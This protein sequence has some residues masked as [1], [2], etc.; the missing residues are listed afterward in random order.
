MFA[1]FVEASQVL[2]D[3]SKGTVIETR[4]DG[5]LDIIRPFDMKANIRQRMSLMEEIQVKL[6]ILH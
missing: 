6:F 5:F 4:P 2:I 1:S 3:A